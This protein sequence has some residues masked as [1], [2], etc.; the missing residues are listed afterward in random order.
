M[1]KEIEQFLTTDH[2]SAIK[3]TT[4]IAA[5]IWNSALNLS[6][7]DLCRHNGCAS[8]APGQPPSISSMCRVFSCVRQWPP[9]AETL[10]QPYAKNVTI[11]RTTYH[12]TTHQ[13]AAPMTTARTTTT[14]NA[15][16][17][18][19]A[20]TASDEGAS[21]C[22]LARDSRGVDPYRT[23]RACRRPR[24]SRPCSYVTVTWSDGR[25][26]LSWNALM[27]RKPVRRLR[28]D[29]E[30]EAA[31]I[32]PFGDLTLKAHCIRPRPR[33]RILNDA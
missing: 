11:L 27:C 16:V 32:I 30:A 13:G 3:P 24:S 12:G 17:P 21:G 18:T 14:K 23:S 31:V 29:D 2:P 6:L 10:S 25:R 22:R 1:Q 20:D 5:A 7:R 9:C 26:D 19:I 8:Q 33:R 28:P 4:L 15:A